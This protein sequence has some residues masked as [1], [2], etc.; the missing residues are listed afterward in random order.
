MQ[1]MRDG[2][3]FLLYLVGLRGLAIL[4]VVLF[5][6]CEQYFSNGFYGVDVFF[7]ISGYLLFVGWRGSDS[8]SFSSF[9]KKKVMRIYP[10]LSALI[11]LA[12]VSAI[13]FM[14][15]AL[16]VQTF[17]KNSLYSLLGV[18]NIYY[19]NAYSDYFAADSN[20]NPLLHTWFLSVAIQ[21]YLLWA[22]GCVLLRHASIRAQQLTL[23]LIASLSLI[24]SLS[25]SIQQIFIDCLGFGWG[26]VA[27]V[28]YYDPLGRVWQVFAGGLVC[29]LPD[30][31]RKGLSSVLFMVGL[32]L[33]C[34]VG[35]CNYSLQSWVSILV[36]IGTVLIL[37]YAQETSICKLLEN[38]PLIFLGQISFSLYLVHFPLLVFYR[39]WERE[40]P[41]LLCSAILL[42][43]SIIV[44]W[45]ARRCIE[46]HK[47]SLRGGFALFACALIPACLARGVFQLGLVWDARS[48][49]Y[50]AYELSTEHIKC[51]ETVYVGYDS[52][53]MKADSGTL[54]ILRSSGPTPPFLSL[55]G[56][57]EAAQFV[58]VGNSVAQELYAGFHEVCKERKIS[59]VHLTS[60]VFPLWDV[61]SELSESYNW[62]EEKAE[63]FIK[64]L[65]HQTELHTVVVS[66]LWK[67]KSFPA[68]STYLTWDGHRKHRTFQALF[69]A[70]KK[71]CECVK[72]AGKQ[73]VFVTPTPVFMEFEDA[74][75]V[76]NGEDYVRWRQL[77]GKNIDPRK[78]EDPFVISKN[79][80]MRFNDDVFLMLNRLEEEGCCQLL[81]IEDAIFR[82]G[83]FA[84]LMGG[85]LFC[86][87]RTH[88]TPPASIYI[89]QGVADRFEE[90]MRFNQAVYCASKHVGN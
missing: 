47:F 17:G 69:D 70:A 52:M 27:E 36:V 37:R 59:G 58:L 12:L 68:V 78:E 67:S 4:M 75:Q 73:V 53:L 87:D 63:A 5:H 35:F 23:I 22:V 28:S 40:S 31:K 19:I 20:M 8:F 9:V 79:E 56:R 38:R 6:L 49:A 85:I 55:Y 11:L 83:N 44:A 14:Y 24:Y 60:I 7:V 45:G 84:G 77:R 13:P 62:T 10:S 39:N 57:S 90:L 46:V 71:F 21:I 61:H 34:G 72:A 15:D 74:W 43:I 54:A 82:D 29:V 66:Y 41:N 76:G 1:L 32:M 16:A 51:S 48:I 88:I 80:Y 3:V 65:R 50:P 33:L 89:M 25:F 2:K 86:R 81:H 26:Q 30:V 42:L 18:S 64:W